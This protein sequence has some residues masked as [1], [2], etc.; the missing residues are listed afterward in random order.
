MDGRRF[1][2]WTRRLGRLSTRRQ[3]A[4]A[5]AIGIAATA[6]RAAAACRVVEGAEAPAPD[7]VVVRRYQVVR[8]PDEARQGLTA[9]YAPLLS[10]QPGFR[11]FV[12]FGDGSDVIA[13]TRFASREQ[14]A[15][16]T[17]ALAD[18][19]ARW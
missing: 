16:A 3:A 11:A 13:I 14:E 8:D 15:A 4:R 1:D 9:G 5:G 2:G 17:A 18:W 12:V 10:R 19:A 6:L 7:Y